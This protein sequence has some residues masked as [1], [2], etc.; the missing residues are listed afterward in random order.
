LDC[1]SMGSR[2]ASEAEASSPVLRAA[3]SVVLEFDESRS[4]RSSKQVFFVE[5]ADSPPQQEKEDFLDLLLVKHYPDRVAVFD[6]SKKI[7]RKSDKQVRND[8]CKNICGYI[9]RRICREF[10]SDNYR[11]EVQGLCCQNNCPYDEAHRFY[12][13]K[14]ELVTGPSHFPLL[15]VPSNNTEEPIKRTFRSFF[16]WFLK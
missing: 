13:S 1:G 15:F 7:R 16:R 12:L 4:N 10:L 3:D 9:T 5:A 11:E 14:I 2:Q 8:Y 6:A